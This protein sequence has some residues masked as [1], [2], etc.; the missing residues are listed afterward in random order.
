MLF[1]FCVLL[2]FSTAFKAVAFLKQIPSPFRLHICNDSPKKKVIEV[3][4]SDLNI[5]MD[6]LA[7]P[8][9]NSLA[10]EA[11]GESKY[12][13]WWETTEN[14]FV[15]MSHEGMRGQ[16]AKAV[17]VQFSQTTV[18]V[19]I[20]SYAVWSGL[21]IDE[22]DELA[23]K[24]EAVEGKDGI[25]VINLKLVKRRKVSRWNEFITSVGVDSIL[26]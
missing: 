25:P 17:N 20:F 10:V 5:H 3:D 7:K 26:S 24:F 6:D 21:L 19:T 14:V 4:V 13:S 23:S 18:T 12:Y 2:F 1:L 15:S 8:L 9:D 11:R 16:P 22:I